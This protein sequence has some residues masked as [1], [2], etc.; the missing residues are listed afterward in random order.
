MNNFSIIFVLLMTTKCI[1]LSG[2]NIVEMK[3]N[4]ASKEDQTAQ[5]G[6]R[7]STAQ[8]FPMSES[9]EADKL[10]T[11][12]R[13]STS[14]TFAETVHD[15]GT[16]A[17]GEVAEHTFTFTNTGD[18][19]LIIIDVETTCGCT[20]PERL[21]EPVLPGEAGGVKVRFHSHGKKGINNKAIAIVTN[22]EPAT[23][24]LS[25]KADVISENNTT[26]SNN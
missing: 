18:R 14:I 25:I 6:V 15:F 17:E 21:E 9:T 26:A 8:S 16:I 12:I 10:F 13:T 5:L 24:L 3:S 2:C 19:P 1:W 11:S 23:T 22:T 4:E 7:T 20:V